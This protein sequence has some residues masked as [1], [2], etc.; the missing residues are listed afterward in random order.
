MRAGRDAH[1]F[2]FLQITESGRVHGPISFREATDRCL[3][4]DHPI[5]HLSDGGWFSD[6][7]LTALVDPDNSCLIHLRNTI[8]FLSDPAS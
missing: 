3:H 1:P 8:I 7:Q 5:P 4:P 2:F 6:A